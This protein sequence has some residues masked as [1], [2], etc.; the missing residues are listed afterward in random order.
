MGREDL[1]KRF[2]HGTELGKYSHLEE[3]RVRCVSNGRLY[4]DHL[5]TQ[6]GRI[7]ARLELGLAGPN[8]VKKQDRVVRFPNSKYLWIVTK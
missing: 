1:R 2:S 6:V 4:H 7:A 8:G 3:V 5:E